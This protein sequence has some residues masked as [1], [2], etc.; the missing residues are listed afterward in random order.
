MSTKCEACGKTVY[1]LEKLSVT[2]GKEQHNFHRVSH[3][4]FGSGDRRFHSFDDYLKTGKF[5]V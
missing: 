3:L 5:C 2:K 1:Q 4:I